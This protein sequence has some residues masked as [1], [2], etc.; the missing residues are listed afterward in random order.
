MKN[1]EVLDCESSR[2]FRLKNKI[3]HYNWGAR[4]DQAFIAHLLGIHPE[5]DQPYA[6][7]WMGVHQNSPSQVLD[8][9]NG[10]TDLS[11]WIAEDPKTR[12]SLHHSP[13]F[14]SGLPYLL[15]VLSAEQPLSIQAHP[16]KTQAEVLHQ[17]DPINYPDANH[18]PEVAIAIDHLDALIGFIKP[19][20]FHDLLKNTPELNNLLFSQN[21]GVV[22]LE[23]GIL[24]LLRQGE[25]QK[26]RVEACI[27]AIHERLLKRNEH[28][29]TE[30][31]FLELFE[32]HG[33]QDIGLLFMFFL[34][35]VHLGPGEAVFLAPG[36][37]HA[38][39]RGNI[40]ECMANSDNVVRL[41]LT[42]KFCDSKTLS[43]ILDFDANR[44]H[45]IEILSDGY[46]SEYLSPTREFRLKS[47][48][49]LQGESRAFSFRSNLTMFLLLEGEISLRWRGGNNSC[50]SVY[51][52]GD[53]FVAPANLN[54]F[55]IQSRMH[56]KLYL[57]DL[58]TN[59]D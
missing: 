21:A 57:V 35:R 17:Q 13:A 7:L 23:L 26:D 31:L 27:K 25:Q 56:S 54:E 20:Q 12:L 43:V 48:N 46:L 59:E 5:L 9:Q 16:N 4:N 51:R 55:T 42:G 22:N 44:E 38:Y 11:D 45:R 37:P 32:A 53:S 14:S 19:E 58:P 52:R 10:S 8:L 40:I 28:S 29:E 36:V 18:K 24:G 47:L 1:I 15:K 41:G 30:Q 33:S 2:P 34:N 3:Q 49:L 39:L 50:T 6:E